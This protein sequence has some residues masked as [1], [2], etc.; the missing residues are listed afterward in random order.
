M[1]QEINDKIALNI[2][3]SDILSAKDKNER[4]MEAD[5]KK[6]IEYKETLKKVKSQYEPIISNKDFPYAIR[7]KHNLEYIFLFERCNKEIMPYENNT[8][9]RGLYAKRLESIMDYVK[10]K[11]SSEKSISQTKAL[12]YGINNVVVAEA[13]T[14]Y[15]T[16]IEE[17]RQERIVTSKF[18]FYVDYLQKTKDPDYE[19][20]VGLLPSNE[21]IE[22]CEDKIARL[23][24]EKALLIDILRSEKFTMENVN[25]ADL[26]GVDV[27]T[28]LY[29][30]YPKFREEI[31]NQ[32]KKGKQ[33][34]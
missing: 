4:L 20:R 14:Y 15:D 18:K 27:K 26:M 23:Q 31:Y 17:A 6:I 19:K 11:N 10:A 13:I 9:K 30:L 32:D 7:Q 16:A 21:E 12:E 25:L 3:I 28:I 24:H 1:G 5:K 33:V 8:K 29:L 2:A 34:A 22:I